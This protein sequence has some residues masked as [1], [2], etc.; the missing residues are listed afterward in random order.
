M[1][2]K[3]A[4]LLFGWINLTTACV[5]LP[6]SEKTDWRIEHE[7]SPFATLSGWVNLGT[8]VQF[9]RVRLHL[10]KNAEI[11][12]TLA[13][14]TTDEHGKFTLMVS[15]QP[16]EPCVVV[17]EGGEYAE[18]ATDKVISFQSS[19]RLLAPISV[20]KEG[21]NELAINAWT[22]LA[23]ARIQASQEQYDSLEKAIAS[24]MLL[25]S[26]HLLSNAEAEA[27]SKAKPI[28][29]FVSGIERNNFNLR[30]H[31]SQLGFS[32][33]ANHHHHISSIE[34]I[35]RLSADLSDGRLEDSESIRSRLVSYIQK[36]ITELQKTGNLGFNPA[37]FLEKGGFYDNLALDASPLLYHPQD[38]TMLPADILKLAILHKV[39]IL[40]VSTLSAFETIHVSAE[41][42][43][44]QDVSEVQADLVEVTKPIE[45]GSELQKKAMGLGM[46]IDKIKT[47]RTLENQ[48]QKKI[49][50]SQTTVHLK[51]G[52]VG[53][54]F[55]GRPVDPQG[56]VSYQV[57]LRTQHLGGNKLS[58][59]TELFAPVASESELTSAREKLLYDGI[60]AN[61]EA[62]V[63]E[64]L[65]AGV[66]FQYQTQSGDTS[67]KAA[68]RLE[69]VKILR[70]LVWAGLELDTKDTDG[71]TV[72][73]GV[74]DNLREALLPRRGNRISQEIIS[75]PN[76]SSLT[77]DDCRE[78]QY[79]A[80]ISGLISHPELK[81]LQ[82]FNAAPFFMK[83]GT[84]SVVYYCGLKF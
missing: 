18:P 26:Q 7:K 65:L 83:S 81:T 8:P 1:N 14:Q 25:M 42:K 10:F 9:A 47:C 46:S 66:S 32:R 37:G 44:P 52:Q 13:E 12:E 54:D 76:L 29:L 61:E 45:C 79:S 69:N 15:K 49:L 63:L 55:N 43:S 40:E 16:Q 36:S 5:D 20:F 30:V 73:D 60:V 35:S 50:E 21:S 74:R 78:L 82:N 6:Y 75:K 3:R 58:F 2:L 27:I 70:G 19:Q 77:V 34:L 72:L 28:N 4:L 11:G 38:R 71:R 22:T 41:V 56:Q 39:K 51:D 57:Q 67:L 24:N 33:L 17:V 64:L 59:E 53:F 84:I 62:L 48:I 80:F 68:I 31:L 23:V